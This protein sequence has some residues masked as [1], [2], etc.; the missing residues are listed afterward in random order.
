MNSYTTAH[1]FNSVLNN[2]IDER[3]PNTERYVVSG[4]DYYKDW[5]IE[6]RESDKVLRYSPYELFKKSQDYEDT[7]EEFVEQWWTMLQ[8]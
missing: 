3:F 1:E 7:L 8:Q 6:L 5:I 2:I 4:G